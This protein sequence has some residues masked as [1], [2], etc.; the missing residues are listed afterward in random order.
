MT[1]D[2][3]AVCPRLSFYACFPRKGEDRPDLSSILHND[4][5]PPL[6]DRSSTRSF[7]AR[8]ASVEGQPWAD[9][10]GIEK[11]EDKSGRSSPLSDNFRRRADS[12]AEPFRDSDLLTLSSSSTGRCWF[13]T[14][15]FCN[16]NCR[17][18]GRIGLICLPFC[19]TITSRPYQTEARRGLLRLLSGRGGW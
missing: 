19:T 12:L 5:Q 7:T 4:H 2:T 16:T 18:R 6:P 11:M 13:A 1:L 14:C 3:V 17:S 10:N 8:K 15:P 9:G